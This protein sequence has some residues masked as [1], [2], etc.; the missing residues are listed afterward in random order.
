MIGSRCIGFISNDDCFDIVN[1]Q[2]GLRLTG[3][4]LTALFLAS[5]AVAAQPVS[6]FATYQVIVST[7]KG[8]HSALV[9]ESVGPS[10]KTGFSDLVLR[11]VGG[12][13]SFAYSRLVNSSENYFPFLSNLATQSFDYSNGTTSGVHLSVAQS[14]TTTLTFNGA[15]YTL[16]VYTITASASYGTK[17]FK[18]NGTIETF[19]STLVYSAEAGNK[20]V[21]VQAVLKATDLPL[22]GPSPVTTAAYVGAGV[23]VGALALGGVFLIR[24]RERKAE[25]KDTKPMHWVD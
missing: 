25:S 14:G 22:N 3:V 1:R 13:Q 21:N 17:S 10:G 20:T 9:N 5:S 16:D 4:F 2:A 7:P 12:A 18:V 15:Q 23:G 19:P 6:G 24:R 8:V 11:I